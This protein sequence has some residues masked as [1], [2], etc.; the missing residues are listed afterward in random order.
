M[1]RVAPLASRA[2]IESFLVSRR[3]NIV[4]KAHLNLLTNAI[5]FFHSL[6]LPAPLQASPLFDAAQQCAS[7]RNMMDPSLDEDDFNV[8][9]ASVV[10]VVVVAV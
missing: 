7:P 10:I 8:C 4:M 1:K 2:S 5:K 3:D 6:Y 9:I